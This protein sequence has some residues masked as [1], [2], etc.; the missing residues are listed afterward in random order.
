PR[1]GSSLIGRERPVEQLEGLREAA[2]RPPERGFEVEAAALLQELNLATFPG[3]PELIGPD[4]RFFRAAEIPLHPEGT[5]QKGQSVAP[6]PGAPPLLSGNELRD[7]NRQLSKLEG[8]GDIVGRPFF[9]LQAEVLAERPALKLSRFTD[10]G[11]LEREGIALQSPPEV[12]G[13]GAVL[14]KGGSDASA[15][16][17]VTRARIL[18]NEQGDRL[19]Q[20]RHR[21][22]G[23]GGH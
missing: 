10:E 9:T 12:R 3:L 14:R 23:F 6:E 17:S 5:G 16:S 18:S 8:H 19:H 7:L 13:M 4:E 22:S 2:L 1:V 20:A 15:I 11:F 21:R